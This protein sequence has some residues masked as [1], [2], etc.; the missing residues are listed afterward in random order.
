MKPIAAAL[1]GIGALSAGVHAEPTQ[2]LNFAARGGAERATFTLK[3]E[4]AGLRSY[5]QASTMPTRDNTPATVRYAES[6]GQPLV[7]SGSLAFDALFAH[8]IAEM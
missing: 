8:A 7:R 3:G 1:I 5:E 2:D 6:A 4:A